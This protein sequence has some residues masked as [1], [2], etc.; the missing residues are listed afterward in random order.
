MTKEERYNMLDT[1]YKASISDTRF[2]KITDEKAAEFRRLFDKMAPKISDIVFDDCFVDT[3]DRRGWLEFN[4]FCPGELH[5]SACMTL[6]QT[7]EDV[8]FDVSRK[9][10]KI[11]IGVMSSLDKFVNAANQAILIAQEPETSDDNGKSDR[12]CI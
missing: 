11:D 4:L 5:L 2:R 7:N 9:K 6:D 12:T 3:C 10:H 8:M 1:S